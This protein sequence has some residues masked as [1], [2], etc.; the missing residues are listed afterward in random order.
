[1][2]TCQKRTPISSLSDDVL[3][4][5]FKEC[6]YPKC[7]FDYDKMATFCLPRGVPFEIMV[8]HVCRRWRHVAINLAAL[9]SNIYVMPF[10]SPDL[11]E[12]YLERSQKRLLDI[13]LSPN[14]HGQAGKEEDSSLAL[15][16]TMLISHVERWRLFSIYSCSYRTIKEIV[17]AI[18]RLSAPKLVH[19][20]VSLWENEHQSN[21]SSPDFAFDGAIFM[22]GAPC[23]SY[24]QCIAVSIRSCWPT[25]PLQA[26]TSLRL[27]TCS[28]DDSHGHHSA[29]PLTRHQ[30]HQLL[31]SVPS[32]RN[33]KLG[34]LIFKPEENTE[35]LVIVLS[36]LVSADFD[37]DLDDKYTRDVMS[38]I[39]SPALTSMAFGDMPAQVIDAFVDATKQSQ[40]WLKY[41]KLT[42]LEFNDIY[43]LP[44]IH[45]NSH[46]VDALPT[47]THISF[48]SCTVVVL[49]AL[50]ELDSR[51]EGT[52]PWPNLRT[53]TI[54]PFTNE[55]VKPLC[56]F[57]AARTGS[58][59]PLES[60]RLSQRDIMTLSSA[61]FFR[62]NVR[63][64]LDEYNGFVTYYTVT[65]E[66]TIT[67]SD[68]GG[69]DSD[70]S[71]PGEDN[72]LED[73]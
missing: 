46:F 34:G 72:D 58:G 13:V 30:F 19:F 15:S 2:N 56:D 71:D 73:I 20:D 43:F 61:E 32:L 23:L 45:L 36:Q 65:E 16:L 60:I 7:I 63:L 5:I 49:E 4:D 9:W 12:T 38:T 33:L 18:R 22:G 44:H 64:D 66:V 59:Y 55:W 6:I 67:R 21:L 37:F 35:P 10:Q 52:V 31:T 17:T 70:D 28:F 3:A 50:A 41:P 51:A 54:N 68:D 27:D 29:A 69:D 14:R 11:L 62:G 40:N 42:R 39:S 26:L 1:M 8:S 53:I 24:F 57:I 47:I 48:R 25:L